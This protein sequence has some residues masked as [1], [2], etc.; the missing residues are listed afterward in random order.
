MQRYWR[1]IYLGNWVG[2]CR[3]SVG[4]LVSGVDAALVLGSG[5]IQCAYM[6]TATGPF[7]SL[8][9]AAALLGLGGGD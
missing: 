6:A 2:R 4:P 8:G 1:G 3:Y 7:R 5:A 9:F